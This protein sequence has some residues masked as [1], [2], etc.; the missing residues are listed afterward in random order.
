M[1]RSYILPILVLSLTA[2]QTE[3]P[4]AEVQHTTTHIVTEAAPAPKAA[5]AP[6]P[7][8]DGFALDVKTDGDG[9][10]VGVKVEAKK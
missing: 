10:S 8:P 2:C 5:E 6:A 3:A 1:N 7:A 9:T 4:P